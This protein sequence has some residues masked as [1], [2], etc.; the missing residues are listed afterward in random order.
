MHLDQVST[1]TA[2]KQ[3][4]IL[5]TERLFLR[6]WRE[7]DLDP[8]ARMMAIRR[9]HALS[10][11]CNP[12]ATFGAPWRCSSASGRCTDAAFGPSSAN[13]TARSSAASDFG[14]Q[15]AGPTWS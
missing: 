6:G 14:N 8:L 9:S 15:K 10:A 13:R 2:M 7:S 5:Q 11:A 4:P 3:I 12:E 1:G